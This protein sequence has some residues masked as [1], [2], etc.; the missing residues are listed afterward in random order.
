MTALLVETR[1]KIT[2]ET[3][4]VFLGKFDSGVWY[5]MEC[6]DPGPKSI[7]RPAYFEYDQ[8]YINHNINKVSRLYGEQLDLIGLWHRHPGSFDSFSSTDD[9]TNTQYAQLSEYGAISGLVNIDPEFRLT[10]YHVSLPLAYEKIPFSVD[11]SRIPKSVMELKD[12]LVY[13]KDLGRIQATLKRSESARRG[14]TLGRDK[15]FDINS[16]IHEFLKKRTFSNASAMDIRW[17]EAE[18]PIEE[19][20]E[21]MELDLNFFEEKGV[22]YSIN[23]NE[24]GL[25]DLS[26]LNGKDVMRFSFGMSSDHTIG[27]VYN[28]ITYK[29]RKG[30]F[31]EAIKEGRRHII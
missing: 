16:S 11:D 26:I 10:M 13:A 23:L 27:F 1:E 14:I 6:I 15:R 29:Y 19:I 3:G 25:L 5:V 18:L 12:P 20:L 22:D 8:A 2:T 28:E 24:T 9:G 7:F 4:G 31:S 30:I 21:A 17:Y